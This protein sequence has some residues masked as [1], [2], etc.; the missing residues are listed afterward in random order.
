MVEVHQKAALAAKEQ[1]GSQ[2]LLQGG[3]RLPVR[4]T[5]PG[6]VDQAAPARPLSPHQ[7]T[8]RETQPEPAAQDLQPFQLVPPQPPTA[9]ER[10]IQ[11]AG[12]DG[13]LEKS[14]GVD[15]IAG[16]G[17]PGVAGAKEQ[18]ADGRTGWRERPHIQIPE[19]DGRRIL[20]CVG[21]PGRDI[22]EDAVDRCPP[23]DGLRQCGMLFR[24]AHMDESPHIRLS[25]PPQ[26]GP[27]RAFCSTAAARTI[28][29]VPEV[30]G[31]GPKDPINI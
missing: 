16:D 3:E 9:V 1:A 7:V 23:G 11:I 6:A 14:R 15:G 24:V 21:R 20:F 25:P 22:Q 2:A 19:E 5:F 31:K 26:I 17:G 30:H 10:R 8:Q 28:I 13:C 12:P 4:E 27:I 18:G 29:G